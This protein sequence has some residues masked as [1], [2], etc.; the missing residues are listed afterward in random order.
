M[1]ETWPFLAQCASSNKQGRI[2]GV[3]SRV[4]L[5]RGSN[6]AVYTSMSSRFI[7]TD[8]LQRWK[9]H[10]VLIWLVF[11]RGGPTDR[12]TDRVTYRVACMQLKSCVCQSL[13]GLLVCKFLCRAHLGPKTPQVPYCT[14]TQIGEPRQVTN[15]SKNQKRL[16][17]L[18]MCTR[19]YKSL[20]RLVGQSVR[21]S[22][23]LSH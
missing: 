10:I 13:I 20:C 21:P 16:W 7:I 19:L 17:F 8:R 15:S 3:I 22:V 9:S 2:H 18:V 14:Q 1:S 6:K 4:L 11:V 5:G 12:P 23:G